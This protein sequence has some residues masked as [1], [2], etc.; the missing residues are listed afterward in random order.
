MEKNPSGERHS[1][2][3]LVG[4]VLLSVGVVAGSAVVGMV[5]GSELPV[6]AVVG[7]VVGP[8]LP[9]SLKN[10]TRFN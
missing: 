2:S 6:P 8:E 3:P 5:V 7:I 4:G 9:G 1:A 10:I